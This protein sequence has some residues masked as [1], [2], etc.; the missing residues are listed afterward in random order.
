VSSD[1]KPNQD[2]VTPLPDLAAQADTGGSSTLLK[3]ANERLLQDRLIEPENDN[4]KY[5]LLT[6]RRLD[7]NNAAL[8]AAMQDLG[9]RLLAKARR[10]FTLQQ[11]EAARSWL[12]AAAGIGPATPESASLQH[13]LDAA[14]AKQALLTT[15]VP[16]NQLTL[17]KSVQ[18]IYPTK[19]ENAKTEGWVE[20]DFTVS[21]SGAVK[22]VSVHAVSTPGVFE[23]AAVKA[24]SQWRYKPFLSDGKQVPVRTE[25]RVRFSLSSR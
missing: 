19:A 1:S 3:N 10:A 7:P 9:S 12:D 23:D 17:L 20:L 14:L 25:I 2:P 24:V 13:D 5:Y 4:A 21:E 16:A 11:Y 18:P 8:P 15:L 22:D 6:L